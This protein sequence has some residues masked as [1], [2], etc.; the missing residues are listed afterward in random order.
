MNEIIKFRVVNLRFCVFE[1]R[2]D[3]FNLQFMVTKRK[4]K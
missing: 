3:T 2:L 4:C 1:E